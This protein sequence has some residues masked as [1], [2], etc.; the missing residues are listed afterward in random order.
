MGGCNPFSSTLLL[1]PANEVWGK[2][3]FSEACVKNSVHRGEGVWYPSMH[4]RWYPSMPCRYLGGGIPACPA[5]SIPVCLAWGVS[6][7]TPE[8]GLQ[9]HTQGVSR[10]TPGGGCVS[11]HALRQTPLP[12]WMATAV[13]GTHPTGMHS[14]F[15]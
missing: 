14:C 7:P 2:A 3:I 4:C 12:P 6:R 9:A 10:T 15:Q 13:C 5:G 11:Q 8:G 1:P